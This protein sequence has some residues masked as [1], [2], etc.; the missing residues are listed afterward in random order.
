MRS[1]I[2][3]H[4]T[5]FGSTVCQIPHGC[6]DEPTLIFFRTIS[7]YLMRKTAQVNDLVAILPGLHC[8]CTIPG[9][10]GS[11]QVSAWLQAPFWFSGSLPLAHLLLIQLGRKWWLVERCDLQQT[12]FSDLRTLL[13][14]PW[15]WVSFLPQA[16]KSP[17]TD[18]SILTLRTL[19]CQLTWN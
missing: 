19:S 12:H 4:H 15:M 7:L 10:T 14:P 6:S 5:Y 2:E 9:G 3:K 18:C 8:W 1:F 16:G 17:H 11:L 13:P